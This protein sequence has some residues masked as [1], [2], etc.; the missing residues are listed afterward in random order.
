MVYRHEIRFA[1]PLSGISLRAAVNGPDRF[2]N[3]GPTEDEI[4]SHRDKQLEDQNQQVLK[5]L[6]ALNDA[7][8]EFEQR[9]QQSI[10]E[11]QQIAV[12]L[13]IMAAS[14]VVHTELDHGQLGVEEFVTEAIDRLALFEKCTVRL[15]PQD[16]QSLQ[17]CVGKTPVPWMNDLITLT[18]DPEIS[19]G[20]IRLEA[21]SGQVVL[22][23][24]VSRLARI[25]DEWTENIGDAQTEQRNVS[26]NAQPVRRFPD[27]RET[28]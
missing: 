23:D 10:G 14:R 8:E 26:S 7:V 2:E 25:H 12:E 3:I 24:A 21:D 1:Q 27:R 5:T 22:S 11:L 19:R 13:A 18:G 15:H 6:E 4:K 16:L 28:A 17:V 9:R 20:G